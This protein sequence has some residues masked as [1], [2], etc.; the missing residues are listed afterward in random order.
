MGFFQRIIEE[1]EYSEKDWETI[2]NILRAIATGEF[3][4]PEI[5]KEERRAIREKAFDDIIWLVQHSNDFS[6]TE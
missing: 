3:E 1:K 4:T 5:D 2:K 6:R